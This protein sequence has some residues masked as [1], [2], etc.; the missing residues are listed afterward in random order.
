MDA[1][2]NHDTATPVSSRANRS[3]VSVVIPTKNRKDQLRETICSV[4][5]QTVECEIIVIDDGSTDDTRQMVQ[6]RFPEVRY[7]KHP[8]SCGPAMSRNRGA[9]IASGEILITLDDDC[10]LGRKDAVEICLRWFDSPEIAG[11]TLPFVNVRQDNVLRTAAPATDQA[12]VT[13]EYFAGMVA[14]RRSVFLALGGYRTDY[15][16][17]YEEPDLAIRMLE[18][19]K[20]IRNGTVALVSHFESPKRDREK[21]WRLGARNAIL[22]ALLNV[23][24]ILLPFY[25]VA[26]VTKTFLFAL[27]RGGARPAVQGFLEAIALGKRTLQNRNP[28]SWKAYCIARRLKRRGPAPIDEIKG[29][30]AHG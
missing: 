24:L 3:T 29:M 18:R 30:F 9:Q 14:F 23:P 27:Q 10:V 21:L 20:L 11:V 2:I 15:F 13:L 5:S 17:H 25:I 28:I 4:R 12:Y 16:M 1:L 7:E 8:E 6:T 19:G 22:Y 26:T